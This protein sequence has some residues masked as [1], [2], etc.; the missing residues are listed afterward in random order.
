MVLFAS[1]RINEKGSEV[2]FR[3]GNTGS[4]PVGDAKEFKGLAARANPF[5]FSQ[6]KEYALEIEL[7]LFSRAAAPSS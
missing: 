1:I 5:S 6:S 3:A 4:N 2:H 7:R